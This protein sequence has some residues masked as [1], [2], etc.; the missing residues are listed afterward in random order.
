MGCLGLTLRLRDVRA[1]GLH[2][3]GE[4]EEAE[5]VA[6][7]PEEVGVRDA[8]GVPGQV[9]GEGWSSVLARRLGAAAGG[10]FC[11]RA[12][13]RGG[14][15][16]QC[17]ARC[18]AARCDAA[19][20]RGAH[21]ELKVVPVFLL[22]RRCSSSTVIMLRALASLYAFAPSKASLGEAAM[23]EERSPPARKPSS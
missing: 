20:R 23:V 6:L 2:E 19:A 10:V 3:R 1:D 17:A 18:D 7:L 14:C 22:R 5:P 21:I 11:G 8:A 13:K 12:A 16:A 9:Q 4:E 15:G